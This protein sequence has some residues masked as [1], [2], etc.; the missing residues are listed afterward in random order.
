MDECNAPT[1]APRTKL[2]SS[3]DPWLCS[4]GLDF[5]ENQAK[6]SRWTSSVGEDGPS[7]GNE[8]CDIS[9]GSSTS[10][11]IPDY[12]SVHD[13]EFDSDVSMEDVKNTKS[14]SITSSGFRDMLL[15][16]ELNRVATEHGLDHL[17]EVQ[18]ECISF[19]N[20]GVD[21]VCEAKSGSGKTTAFVLSTLQQLDPVHG[22]VHVLVLV[23]TPELAVK[24]QKEYVR[25]CEFLPSIKTEVLGIGG[26]KISRDAE[27][28]RENCPHIVI[29]T[30][31]RAFTMI[32]RG[33]LDVKNLKHLILDECEKIIG[34]LEWRS[35]VYKI[36]KASSP[37]KQ[38]MLFSTNISDDIKPICEQLTKDPLD[39]SESKV[40]RKV[41]IE[42]NNIILQYEDGKKRIVSGLQQFHLKVRKDT[43]KNQ[44]L[45]KLL[46]RSCDLEVNQVIIFVQ[47]VKVCKDLT[48]VLKKLNFSTVAIH[49][50]MKPVE[51]REKFQQFKDFKK[52]ILV[53]TN[54]FDRSLECRRVNMVFNYDMPKDDESYLHRV[55]RAGRKHPNFFVGSHPVVDESKVDGMAITFI[56]NEEDYKILKEV[57][58][59]LKCN[60]PDFFSKLEK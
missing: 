6:K 20:A 37:E 24:I 57:Q 16:P 38:V 25:F 51:K 46:L 27:I 28:L 40:L 50:D 5:V 52:K 19:G 53:T 43:E 18:I 12:E 44:E 49:R 3:S 42:K 29:G 23:H 39:Y 17:N 2:L 10:P 9:I 15:K 58:D 35:I 36:F 41:F 26:Q 7:S 59:K 13:D 55:A 56:S 31:S 4:P 8:D 30:P 14:K 60:I 45:T 11:I 21:V 48:Y 22:E 34:Q 54:V 32:N 33:H 47:S 1:P